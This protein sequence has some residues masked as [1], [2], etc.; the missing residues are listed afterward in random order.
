M[1]RPLGIDRPESRGLDRSDGIVDRRLGARDEFNHPAIE[2]PVG[3]LR[4]DPD[5]TIVTPP[6]AG[7]IR[8]LLDVLNMDFFK[9][10]GPR[11]I[12]LARRPRA[13]GI[14]GPAAC[15]RSGRRRRRRPRGRDALR[16]A[17][18][19]RCRLPERPR[20]SVADPA[21]R[22]GDPPPA[23]VRRAERTG[24]RGRRCRANTP[25]TT[26]AP[27]R[28]GSIASSASPS[29]GG[30]TRLDRRDGRV[31]SMRASHRPGRSMESIRR[32]AGHDPAA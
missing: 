19:P 3:G 4:H 2:S 22:R 30:R 21:R 6:P 5:G 1:S 16:P 13:D 7:C 15:R 17:R 23:V 20:P 10:D 26:R 24:D 29:L 28:T 14:T 31:P 9:L 11:T 25:A 27:R 8:N 32:A 12:R 18:P